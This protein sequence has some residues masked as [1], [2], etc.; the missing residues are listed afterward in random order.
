MFSAPE[1]TAKAIPTAIHKAPALA[2]EKV[3]GNRKS[4]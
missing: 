2:P 3:Q 1:D 4:G